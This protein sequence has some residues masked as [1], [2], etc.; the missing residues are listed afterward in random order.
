[1]ANRPLRVG[2]C[3]SGGGHLARATLARH[4]ALAL[5]PVVVVGETATDAGVEEAA[6]RAGAK[7]FRLESPERAEFDRRLTEILLDGEL[8]LLCLTFDK[9]LPTAVV[10]RYAPRIVNVHMSLLPAFVG[11]HGLRRTAAAGVRFGGATIHEVRQG[12]DDGPIVAQ[13]IVGLRRGESESTLGAR[14][15]PQ[16]EAMF[17][18]VLRWYAEDRVER[19]AD[20]RVWIRDAIYGELPISP[21]IEQPFAPVGG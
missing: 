21:A 13:C 11:L 15:Y 4:D 7:W 6:H 12:T 8:D 2:F 19:D 3:V 10:E 16:L 14:L 9:L 1:M 17:L 20:G 5:E 18:Q